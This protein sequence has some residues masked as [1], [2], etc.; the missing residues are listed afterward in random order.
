MS[1]LAAPKT[2]PQY[3]SL[4]SPKEPAARPLS[5]VIAASG[6]ATQNEYDETIKS[7]ATDHATAVER[8]SIG[9][10]AAT[11]NISAAPSERL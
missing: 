3:T 1:E 4:A 9:K 11:E 7:T 5:S 8:T 2:L 6:V 10:T